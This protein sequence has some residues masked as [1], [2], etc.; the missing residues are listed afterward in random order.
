MVLQLKKDYQS[1]IAVRAAAHKLAVAI[2][3]TV[4]EIREAVVAIDTKTADRI[5]QSRVRKIEDASAAFT[6]L[7]TN[8]K[9][10]SPSIL[11][12]R[13]ERQFLEIQG[14]VIDQR[15]AIKA[16]AERHPR[17]AERYDEILILLTTLK[18]LDISEV[19]NIRFDAKSEA[20]ANDALIVGTINGLAELT[21]I[22]EM[23][24]DYLKHLGSKFVQAKIAKKDLYTYLS[25]N[26]AQTIQY[27]KESVCRG[28]L[29]EFLV[30]HTKPLLDK[31]FEPSTELTTLKDVRIPELIA[32][33]ITTRAQV[34]YF[35]GLV[36]TALEAK[37]EN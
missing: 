10:E 15:I 2:K 3:A 23:K 30:E 22:H 8:P 5:T 7:A 27:F 6:K 37:N 25:L 13:L 11:Q 20:I 9:D 1:G 36:D 16:E 35:D 31:V 28:Q 26:D 34:T 18:D 32:K 29:S 12:E 17:G 21:R 24:N 19:V 4:E 14:L 33:Y